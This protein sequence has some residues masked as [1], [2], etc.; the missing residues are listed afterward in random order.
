MTTL[1]ES[2]LKRANYRLTGLFEGMP[3]GMPD[4]ADPRFQAEPRYEDC[5]ECGGTGTAG[6]YDD[7]GNDISEDEYLRRMEMTEEDRRDA[8]GAH[9]EECERCKGTGEIE[10]APEEEYDW[11][12]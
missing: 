2:E 11:D 1:F 7:D 10:A 6:Y 4:P 12:W 3:F 8:G 9:R 5:P